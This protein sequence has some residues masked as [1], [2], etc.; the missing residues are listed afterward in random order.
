MFA[1]EKILLE[2]VQRLW[3]VPTRFVKPLAPDAVDATVS[4]HEEGLF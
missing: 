3:P 1:F 2:L 4:V